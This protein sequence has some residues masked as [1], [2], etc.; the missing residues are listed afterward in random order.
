MY[1]AYGFNWPYFSYATKFNYV[2]IL[3]AFN[4]NFIQRYQLPKHTICCHQTFLTDTH[5]FYCLCE[6]EEGYELYNIDL[7]SLEPYLDGP[8]FHYSH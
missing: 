8:L 6:T 1:M 3:N 5:D 7:D 2:F 4:S